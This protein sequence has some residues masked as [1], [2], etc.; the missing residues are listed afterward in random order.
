MIQPSLMFHLQVLAMDPD[1]DNNGNVTYTLQDNPES[2]FSID[3]A[4]GVLRTMRRFDREQ[5]SSY[6]LVV[7]ARDRGTP[8]MSSTAV[9]HVRIDD[10]NDNPTMF[11]STT[12]QFYVEEE[13]PRGTL[14]DTLKTEDKDD[15]APA[16]LQFSFLPD[17]PKPPEFDIDVYTGRITTARPLD[18]ESGV[19]VYTFRVLVVDADN[20]VFSDSANVTVTVTDI[21]DH[22]PNVT[23]PVPGNNT[24]RLPYTAPAGTIV[25]RVL[26]FDEDRGENGT[27][28]LSFSLESGDSKEMFLMNG[29]SGELILTRRLSSGD[30]NTYHLRVAVQD[31]GQRRQMETV[32]TLDVVVTHSN[33]SGFFSTGGSSDYNIAIVVTLVCVTFALALAV[34]ATICIIR[35]IDRERKHHCS[36]KVEEQNIYKQETLPPASAAS[37][38]EEK[39]PAMENYE[40]EIE[41][42]KRKIKRELSFASDDELDSSSMTK[43][44]TSTTS[45]ST[46]KKTSP[47]SSMDHKHYTVSPSFFLSPFHLY[48]LFSDIM[49]PCVF[50][51]K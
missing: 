18:R 17:T 36:T 6:R 19:T 26:A 30:V 23:F 50:V 21:N 4:S 33:A 29:V 51:F 47:P 20:S 3:S 35:R 25:T 39:S 2:A 10:V 42:L 44:T 13:Q 28:G 9:V 38:F 27:A 5:R 15:M 16:R 40:N 37:G 43:G 12:F 48:K 7:R 49:F 31:G 8:A 41:K 11:A 46:F 22:A 1:T 34:L 24:V 32:M 45:F 14:V